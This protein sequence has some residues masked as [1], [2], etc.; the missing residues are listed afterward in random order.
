M[1]A[2]IRYSDWFPDFYFDFIY[3]DGFAESGQEDGKTLYDWW[4]K[5]NSGGIFAGD[6]YS[7]DWP[8]TKKQV[9][10]FCET[11]G[12]YPTIIPAMKGQKSYFNR[13]P[14]YYMRK[15]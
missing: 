3:I 8:E 14:S 2:S 4:P 5:L 1:H 9:D 7:D 15:P 10:I 11:L 12:L 6:D 13:Q